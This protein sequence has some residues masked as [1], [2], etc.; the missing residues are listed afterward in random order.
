M[1]HPFKHWRLNEGS[2]PK[3]HIEVG[4]EQPKVRKKALQDVTYATNLPASTL[5]ILANVPFTVN[6]P[7]LKRSRVRKLLTTERSNVT[8]ISVSD[9]VQL[10]DKG[11]ETNIIIAFS[12]TLV[13]LVSL[14]I[15]LGVKLHYDKKHQMS[16]SSQKIARRK[17]ERT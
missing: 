7:P 2:N 13:I 12:V 9:F 17:Q 11:S 8:L 10:D 14:G 16:T 1:F 5:Q 4:V 3:Y 6:Q 15:G